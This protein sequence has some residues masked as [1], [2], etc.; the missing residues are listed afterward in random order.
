V[1]SYLTNNGD[2]W[3]TAFAA[4]T[5]PEY[6]SFAVVTAGLING[7]TIVGRM[8]NGLVYGAWSSTSVQNAPSARIYAL[9]EQGTAIAVGVQ[10]ATWPT[11]TNE[12]LIAAQ[13]TAADGIA[14]GIDIGGGARVVNRATGSILAEAETAVAIYYGSGSADSTAVSPNILNEG[15]I[16]AHSLDSNSPSIGIQLQHLQTEP[17]KLVNRGTI[18]ADLA[19]YTDS[20]AYSPPQR[21]V[22]EIV[23]EAGGLIQGVIF[24]DLGNDIVVNSGTIKGVVLLGRDDDRFDNSLGIL[25]G[26][27]DLGPGKDLFLGSAGTDAAIGGRDDDRL[28][29]A[30]GEDLLLGGFGNDTLIGGA[31][32][33]GLFGEFGN[34]L[35]ITQ[36]SDFVWGGTGNDRIE[37][38]DYTFELID[39]GEG[40]DTL[41]LPAGERVLDLSLVLAHKAL[42]AIEAIETRG[43]QELAVRAADVAELAGGSPLRISSLSTDRI[44]LIGTWTESASRTIDGIAYRSFASGQDVVLISGGPIVAT[45]AAP[46]AGATGLDPANGPLAPLPGDIEGVDLTS[47]TTIVSGPLGFT[48]VYDSL[49]IGSEETWLSENGLPVVGGGLSLSIEIVNAGVIRSATTA[50][51][52]ETIDALHYLEFNFVFRGL[53]A[54]PADGIGAAA[55]RTDNV[56][57]IV[58]SGTISAA[59]IGDNTSV[60]VYTIGPG[61]VHNDGVIEAT[62]ETGWA[63]GVATTEPGDSYNDP[64]LFNAGR[65]TARSAGTAVAAHQINFGYVV[66]MGRI[67]AIGGERAIAVDADAPRLRNSGEI[68]A[69]ATKVGGTSYG[70]YIFPHNTDELENSGLIQAQI[71]IYARGDPNER[72]ETFLNLYFTNSGIV[73]GQILLSDG[74]ENIWNTGSI[75]GVILFGGG[76][77]LYD[78]RGGTQIG[79]VYGEDGDDRL[80]GGDATDLFWGG[81]GADALNGGGGNDVLNGGGGADT[82]DGG[83]GADRF[84]YLQASDSAASAPDRIVGFQT[85][86][87]KIDLSTLGVTSIIWTQQTDTSDGSLYNLVDIQ[88]ANGAM[89]IRVTGDGLAQT[90]F[91]REPPEPGRAVVG[92]AGD[93]LLE[94]G[95]GNDSL[96]GLAGN[97]RMSGHAGDDIYFVEDA[98]DSVVESHGEG[99][100]RIFASVSFILSAGQE[101]ETLGV[102]DPVAANA[103]NLTGNEFGQ[104][105][106]GNAGANLLTGGGGNDYLVG[107]GGD[108]V[109][110]GNADAASTL[111]GGTG[112]D[113]YYVRRT[114]DSVVERAGEGDD[115][116]VYTSVNFTLSGGQEVELLSTADPAATTGLALAGN[117]LAQI[118]VGNAGADVLVGGGGS[119]YLVGLGGDDI[120]VGNADAA[121]T[122]QGGTGNDW[123]YVYRTGDSIVEFAG[124]GNDRILTSVSYT[125][126]AG[127]EIE[128]LSALDPAAT[129]A[130]GLTGNALGQVINGNAGANVLTGGGGNDYLVGLGGDDIL[131]GN[132]DAN[133]TL[134][135]GTGN[136]WYYVSR[137]GDSLVEFAGEGNDRILTSVSYTLSAG[138]EI[139]TLS[140]VDQNGTAAIDLIGNDFAQVIFGTNGANG[141]SGNGGADQLA[142]FGGEDVILGGDGDDQ[143][144]G[145]L[146]HDVLN[147]GNGA[148]L[149]VFADALGG[150]NVDTVSDFA[151]GADRIALDHNIF[152]GIATGPLSAGAFV[153]GNAALDADDRIIYNQAAGQLWFDADGNG[154]GDPVLFA[155]LANQP[156][157]ITAS[158]FVVI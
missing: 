148:D 138:Q 84:V 103:I 37:L 20:F 113:W 90:D 60:A 7:G 108:D 24:L 101:V 107:L 42:F 14:I 58:N 125:L 3:N 94:G 17:M 131:I 75:N 10:F 85:G 124:E 123:Y 30:G 65:I 4:N 2:L 77:D 22:D 92:T 119:D 12:G 150:G 71:A 40:F 34:D 64:G 115:D 43:G 52:A 112:N 109:L 96:D 91:V 89:T 93:D 122:L 120:L 57:H 45:L 56:N 86:I 133:S 127:Q 117:G 80:I 99:D 11:V 13:A 141:M 135:G 63:I 146:G 110:V 152:T 69:E 126:S 31:G 74:W 114:G 23:N 44:D 118:I 27:A 49:S 151:P 154:A 104:V 147:G 72:N 67:E 33:D 121:S 140:A 143:L 130:L 128:T 46:P 25:D 111:E 156:T 102:L 9:T 29:G 59:T 158:D 157:T 73:N 87:D 132:A 106:G 6:P 100:D 144:N 35:I 38:G 21:A 82:I 129:T 76:K 55:L 41:V 95:S 1:N 15:L 36:G 53:M 137:T 32:N 50:A 81:A 47:A 18:T 116:R 139:E 149:F 105:I 66:N 51:Q 48:L 54:G 39:G 88:T 145:G 83:S 153:V 134:Q 78:G 26:Y 97:D 8:D 155:T 68:V 61:K 62:T 28:E 142:G 70:I 5:D 98:G 19:I 79:G 136:D 16:R